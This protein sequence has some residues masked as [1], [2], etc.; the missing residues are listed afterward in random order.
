MTDRPITASDLDGL[1]ECLDIAPV[2]CDGMCRLVATRLARAGIPYQGMLGKLIVADRVVSPHYWIDV[3]LFRIDFCARMWLGSD[4]KIPHG[5]FPLDWRLS[6]Q[7]TGIKVQIDP[8]PPSV[9]EIMIMPFGLGT[10]ET[11]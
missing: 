6:A 8:L 10:P 7:Y 2:E 3:G 9:Y 11:R 1:L 5:V 4:P